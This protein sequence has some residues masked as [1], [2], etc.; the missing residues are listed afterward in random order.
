MGLTGWE[1]MWVK[2]TKNCKKIV[3]LAFLGQNSGGR[4]EDKGALGVVGG[5]PSLSPP[6]P[7]PPQGET[8]YGLGIINIIT[9]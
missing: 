1:I 5:V 8:L 9:F 4:W 3:K 6:S 2:Q 7:P